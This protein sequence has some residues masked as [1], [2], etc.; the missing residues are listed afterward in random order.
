MRQLRAG[1]IV[2]ALVAASLVVPLLPS[3]VAGPPD[4]PTAG[5]SEVDCGWAMYGRDAAR[6]F[7]ADDAGAD[8]ETPIDRTTAP[9]LAPAWFV[10]TA[11]TV[12]ASPVVKD[13]RVFVGDWTGT[14]YA[15]DADSGEVVWTRSTEPAPGAPF[16]P[17]VSSAAVAP[18]SEGR[19]LVVVGSGP[20]LYAFEAD[21]GDVAWVS[22][23][24]SGAADP[25]L[26]LPDDHP[27]NEQTEIES[28]PVIHD[29]VVI[30]GM[31]VHNRTREANNGVVGGVLAV[32]LDTGSLTNFFDPEWDLVDSEGAALSGCSSVWS[33][34]TLNLDDD[35][36]YFAT[37]NC[38]HGI[39]A[40]NWGRHTEAVS[41]ISLSGFLD[42]RE[43]SE[44][45]RWSFSPTPGN[46]DDHDFGATPNLF[47]DA[48]GRTVLGAAKKDGVYYALDP[49]TGELLWQTGVVETLRPR[50][51]FDVG[52]FIGSPATGG[53][54]VFGAT[55]IGGPPFFHSLD[56]TNGDLRWQSVAG[57][58]YAAAAHSHGVV[59]AGALDSVLK[60]F[61]ADTGALLYAAPLAGP[62]SSG[63]AIVGDS[64]YIGSGTSS[65]DL[66]AKDVPG[67]EHCLQFF[68]DTLGA[69]GGVHAFRLPGPDSPAPP[70]SFVQD[71]MLRAMAP[72]TS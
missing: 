25:A 22:Y 34:P 2:T 58:S 6:T 54:N 40:E 29:G 53:G 55:A 43:E 7:D 60:V 37:G 5:S 57:P 15:I 42:G 39:P 8:C 21:T 63:P 52:G 3:A 11:K 49:T 1:G 68:D 12:T 28:S 66:C 18:D 59:V 62:I 47:T 19:D 64:V 70:T 9:T 32:D 41:A 30:V 61:E 31:D 14:M 38:P 72:G 36:L 65:S 56:G 69:T 13:G 10:K 33:S 45:V 23:F 35:L 24:G 48:N 26:G 27:E 44:T 50:E 16:G 51:N 17:I 46:Q 4:G 71:S 20:R 67:S